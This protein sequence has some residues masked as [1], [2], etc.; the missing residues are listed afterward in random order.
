MRR[1]VIQ[2]AESTQLI[3]LPRQWA[4]RYNIK[5]G[6]ELEVEEEGSGLTVRPPHGEQEK[7]V[8]ITIASPDKFL[9]RMIG[10]PYAQ[11]VTELQ[12]NYHDRRVFDKVAAEVLLLIGWEIVSQNATSCTIKS[13]ATT[14]ENDLDNIIRRIFLSTSLMMQDIVAAARAGDY[15]QLAA[16]KTREETNN[17]L[18]YFS[19]R[20]LTKRGYADRN[21]T[22]SLYYTLI[23]VEQMVDN[24]RD[25]C[26]FIISGKLEIEPAT[27]AL[28]EETIA[29]FD[30]VQALFYKFSTDAL[31]QHDKKFKEVAKRMQAGLSK[32]S[33]D[34]LVISNLYDTIKMISHLSREIHY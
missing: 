17:K 26:E 22:N 32:P 33:K 19:M 24:L 15:A 31:F 14:L 23:L 1:K 27:L 11:G 25:I 8:E 6:D 7:K 28:F 10:S 9:K 18:T 13:V 30:G 20:L 16:L 5:K 4:Q 12:V 21:K 2:I 29:L 34:A 3:S